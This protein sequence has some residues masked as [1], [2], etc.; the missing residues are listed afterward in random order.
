MDEWSTHTL[1]LWEIFNTPDNLTSDEIEF[2]RI[3]MDMFRIEQ[4]DDETL[5]ELITKPSDLMSFII[6]TVRIHEQFKR[7]RSLP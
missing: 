6:H 7:Q 4:D 1:E 5:L 3:Y 2:A